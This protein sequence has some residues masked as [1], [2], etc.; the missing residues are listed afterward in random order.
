[1]DDPVSGMR[2][3]AAAVADARRGTPTEV[4]AALETLRLLRDTLAAWE[5]ELISAARLDG[6]SW[7]ALAPALGVASRQ[8]AERRYLRLQPTGTGET[9]GEARVDAQRD[10]RAGD[11]AVAEWARHNAGVLRRLA[12][13]V[14]DLDDLGTTARAHADEVDKALAD[15]DPATLLP[16]LAAARPHLACDHGD[17]ADQIGAITDHTDHLRRQA[18]ANR[19]RRTP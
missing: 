2:A 3:V 13:R 19:R 14:S 9:T 17:L 18:G 4:L 12:G 10:R 8:A 11:R 1:M 7:A 5:P 6:T 16:P 15:S